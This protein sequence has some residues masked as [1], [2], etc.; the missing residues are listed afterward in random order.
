MSEHTTGETRRQI[1]GQIDR[2]RRGDIVTLATD[3]G[4]RKPRQFEV[5]RTGEE[6]SARDGG[7]YYRVH[8]LGPRDGHYVAQVDKPK[9]KGNHD[10]PELFYSHPDSPNEPDEETE[11]G[12]VYLKIEIGELVE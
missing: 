11:G 3:T 12:I 4:I 2:L 1:S 9:S 7:I 10:G 5:E 6:R 8:L